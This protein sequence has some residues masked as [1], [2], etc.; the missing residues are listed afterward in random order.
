MALPTLMK[1]LMKKN[2]S[3]IAG[4]GNDIIEIERIREAYQEHGE[5]FLQ[6]ILTEKE[7]LY[8]F[9]HQDPMPHLAGR[10]C[11]KEAISKALG[12]GIG[13]EVSFR[14]MEIVNND[15]GKPEVF[16]LGMM[17]STFEGGSILLSISHCKLYVTA[18]AT[19][20]K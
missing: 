19:W 18:V 11:A 7:R 1:S 3:Q 6:R 9:S 16:F 5:R 15:K 20:L 8:C 17:A 13:A 14:E 10:F 12:L 2:K 4:L